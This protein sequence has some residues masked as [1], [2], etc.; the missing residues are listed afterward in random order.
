MKR[1]I[2]GWSCCAAALLML[3][4]CGQRGTSLQDNTIDLATGME[5]IQPL[6]VSDVAE[7][8]TYVPLETTDSSLI[9]NPSNLL[10]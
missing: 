4:T 2:K 1:Q 8:V 6:N 5:N 3:A 7:S 9:G 10:V